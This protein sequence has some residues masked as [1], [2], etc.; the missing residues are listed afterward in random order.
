MKNRGLHKD[1]L[2]SDIQALARVVG[3]DLAAD[4]TAVSEMTPDSRFVDIYITNTA[5]RVG[6]MGE[7]RFGLNGVVLAVKCRELMES[8]V[9]NNGRAALVA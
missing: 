6:E 2:V 7:R 1:G 8:I 9:E 3:A 4:V 5:R